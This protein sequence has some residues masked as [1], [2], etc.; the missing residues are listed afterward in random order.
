[1]EANKQKTQISIKPSFYVRCT[2]IYLYWCN[3]V[4]CKNC[5]LVAQYDDMHPVNPCPNCGKSLIEHVG[6]WI[7]PKRTWYGKLIS[8]GYWEIQ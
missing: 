5:N 2:S 8:K 7:K 3:V 1:M 4:I 6:R